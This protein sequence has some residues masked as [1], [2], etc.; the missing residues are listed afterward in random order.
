MCK[1]AILQKASMADFAQSV[2]VE[3]TEKNHHHPAMSVKSFP[4]R[5]VEHTEGTSNYSAA[6]MFK[7]VLL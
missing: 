6:L 4:T 2:H 1:R 3:G 5:T 7:S